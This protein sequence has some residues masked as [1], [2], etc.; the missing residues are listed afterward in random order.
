MPPNNRSIVATDSVI[1]NFSACL[2]SNAL[3]FP[4]VLCVWVRVLAHPVPLVP[5]DN[6]REMHRHTLARRPNLRAHHRRPRSNRHRISHHR[7]PWSNRCRISFWAFMTFGGSGGGT[8]KLK[9]STTLTGNRIVVHTNVHRRFASTFKKIQRHPFKTMSMFD[10]VLHNFGHFPRRY[11]RGWSP[12]VRTLT[13]FRR[14]AELFRWRYLVT[15]YPLPRTTTSGV[16]QKGQVDVK[17]PRNRPTSSKQ[18]LLR[19]STPPH[20]SSHCRPPRLLDGSFGFVFIVSL[21]MIMA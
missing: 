13:P 3:F 6:L 9:F 1:V 17:R 2:P 4:L 16:A 21:E 19:D 18:V 12:K 10:P 20:F 8:L 15:P 11:V 7:H 14:L 5:S